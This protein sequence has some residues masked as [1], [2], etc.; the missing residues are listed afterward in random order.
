MTYD[1]DGLIYSQEQVFY[2]V[3]DLVPVY[4]YLYR[5]NIMPVY[6]TYWT[7]YLD[8]GMTEYQGTFTDKDF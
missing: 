7:E 8:G 6:D 1:K 2:R 5:V 3:R 4:E